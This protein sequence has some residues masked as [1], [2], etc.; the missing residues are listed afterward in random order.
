MT[1]RLPALLTAL[2]AA[3]CAAA[4]GETPAPRIE[5]TDWEGGS[6]VCAAWRKDDPQDAAPVWTG[7]PAAVAPFG[8][9]GY[10]GIDGA[11]RPLRQ[12]AYSRRGTELA[13]HYRTLG[14]RAYD[15]RLDLSASAAEGGMSGAL[16]VSRF[17]VE[18]TAPLRAVCAGGELPKAQ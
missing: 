10:V 1:H 15:V 16:T 18:T 3:V 14:E 12:I 7:L 5:A 17:G 8:M 6:L 11:T 13:I 9:R 2:L 4:A